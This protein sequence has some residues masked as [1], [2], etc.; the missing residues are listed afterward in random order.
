MFGIITEEH[1]GISDT[2]NIK[3]EGRGVLCFT[4]DDVSRWLSLFNASTHLFRKP[5]K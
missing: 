5:V 2:E 1:R 4:D 3:A